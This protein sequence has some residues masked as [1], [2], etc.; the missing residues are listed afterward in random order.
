MARAG[1]QV[2]AVRRLLRDWQVISDNHWCTMAAEERKRVDSAFDTAI[3]TCTTAITQAITH[4]KGIMADLHA[5][6]STAT[7][8]Q[9]ANTLCGEMLDE[10]RMAERL[11]RALHDRLQ[12]IYEDASSDNDGNESESSD[13]DNADGE[14]GNP[15]DDNAGN[16]GGDDGDGDDDNANEGGRRR[17]TRN[18]AS[19]LTQQ[20]F[21][22]ADVAANTDLSFQ[23]KRNRDGECNQAQSRPKRSRRPP[24]YR[25]RSHSPGR[26][27]YDGPSEGD[28]VTGPE[29]VCIII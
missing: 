24:R 2:R 27:D 29:P 12:G 5:A 22:V 28:D 25:Q 20:E 18:R 16:S 8:E 13:T 14:D 23:A 6:I 11:Q 10:K 19:R 26:N 1:G 7:N 3:D 21:P 9:Q 15:G 17:A 4:G